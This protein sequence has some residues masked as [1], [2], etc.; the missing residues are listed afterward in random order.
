MGGQDDRG[1]DRHL[2]QLVDEHGASRLESL[3]DVAV[4][5]D[6]LADVHRRPERLQRPLD[7]VDGALDA[8]TERSRS[9]QQ[10]PTATAH[11]A[12]RYRPSA[13]TGNTRR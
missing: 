5:D 8:R 9:G 4:V 3:H 11:R 13:I 6:L 12:P 1:R 10:D 7:G 2:R